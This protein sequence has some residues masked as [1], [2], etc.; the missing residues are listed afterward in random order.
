MIFKKIFTMDNTKSIKPWN[1][2]GTFCGQNEC[3][4]GRHRMLIGFCT[5]DQ[6]TKTIFDL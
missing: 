3:T 1:I 6:S 2:R 5:S 4:A